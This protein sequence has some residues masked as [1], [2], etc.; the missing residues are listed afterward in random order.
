MYWKLAFYCS[1]IEKPA[2]TASSRCNFRHLLFLREW[3]RPEP[4]RCILG[5]AAAVIM[6]SLSAV[7]LN[8]SSEINGQ[9]LH[10]LFRRVCVC[11]CSYLSV[12]FCVAA[13]KNLNTPPPHP[14]VSAPLLLSLSFYRVL[15]SEDMIYYAHTSASTAGRDYKSKASS[16]VAA[17]KTQ[18]CFSPTERAIKS[19]SQG[20]NTLEWSSTW[21][22]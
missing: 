8:K 15:L 16:S 20:S 5:D 18:W 19:V 3:K 1:L 4:E 2:L 10:F 14:H 21:Q 7:N 17:K 12:F 22:K 13:H 11:V 9:W 6:T